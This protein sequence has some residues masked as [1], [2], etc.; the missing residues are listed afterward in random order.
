MLLASLYFPWRASSCSDESFGGQ[1]GTVCGLLHSFP[2][3][4]T[5]EGLSPE[6][7][8]AAALFALVLAAVGVAA[9]ARPG[10][11]R[12]LPLGRCALLAGYFGIAVGIQTRSEAHQQGVGE[13]FHFAYGA[14]VGLAATIVILV[15][16]GVDRRGELAH[17]RS[18]TGL[19]LLLLVAGLLGA[20]LL[21]WL[22]VKFFVDNQVVASFTVPRASRALPPP[23]P[24]HSRYA[25]RLPGRDLARRLWSGSASRQQSLFTGGAAVS[26]TPSTVIG[27]TECG[28]RS[29]SPAASSCSRWL[30][31]LEA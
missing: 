2:S 16:A 25:C 8:R 1:G 11:A 15:A 30:P 27:P 29:G 4:R 5:I 18:A 13:T 7:G 12:R 6:V 26:F 9:W 23:S 19:V 21:P 14:Y 3:Q 24:Q 10:L 20:F 31:A 22:H 17:Y 28:S